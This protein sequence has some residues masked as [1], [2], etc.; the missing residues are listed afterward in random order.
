M[1]IPLESEWATLDATRLTV[2]GSGGQTQWDPPAVMQKSLLQ[3]G[4]DGEKSDTRP[5]SLE[6]HLRRDR[7]SLGSI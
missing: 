2:T 1:A 7:V 4:R 6:P 5:P 3:C